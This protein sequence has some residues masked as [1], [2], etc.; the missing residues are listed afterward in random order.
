M[1][2]CPGEIGEKDYGLHEESLQFLSSMPVAVVITG[3]GDSI[4]RYANR[5]IQN[6]LGISP[7]QMVGTSAPNYYINPEVRAEMV[8]LLQRDGR[9]AAHEVVLRGLEGEQ[10]VC[11]ISATKIQFEAEDCFLFSLLNITS[12]KKSEAEVE[13]LSQALQHSP[14]AVFMCDTERRS[15]YAN[16]AFNKMTGYTWDEIAK[17][18]FEDFIARDQEKRSYDH[19]WWSLDEGKSWRGELQLARRGERFFWGMV[20]VTPILIGGDNASHFVFFLEDITRRKVA[21]EVLQERLHFI[22]TL[23]DAVP[24]PIYYKNLEGVYQGCNQAFERYFGVVRPLII[25]KSLEDVHPWADAGAVRRH[26]HQLVQNGGAQV[27]ETPILRKDG[28]EREAI[29]HKAVYRSSEGTP[30]GIVGCITDI[31]ERKKAER[32]ARENEATLSHVLEGI[33]AGIMVVD[34]QKH[35]VEDMNARAR[36]MLGDHFSGD[37]TGCSVWDC[38]L[39]TWRDES[40]RSVS[41]EKLLCPQQDKEY[42][43]S[44]ENG[45]G[46]PVSL[47]VLPTVIRGKERLLQILFDL[48]E[49]KVLE[50]QLNLAQKLES[51]GQLAAGIAHE[52]NTPVQYVGSNL[53]YIKEALG[54]LRDELEKEGLTLPQD[55]EEELREELPDAIQDAEEGVGRVSAIVQAMRKFSHPGSEDAVLVDVNEAIRNTVTIAR[56]EWKY[57]SEIQLE[58]ADALPELPCIPGD[59]NQVLLNILVNAAHAVADKMGD[60]GRKGQIRISTVLDGEYIQI[61]IADNGCGIPEEHRDVIF[62]PFF[63][64]KTVGRGTGQGLAITHAIVERQRGRIDFSSTPGEGTTFVIRF[65]WREAS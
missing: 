31:T 3:A 37:D 22:Q 55:V 26:D 29:I 11:L 6:L 19:M 44:Q 51:V 46:L 1:A 40:G 57:H 41:V 64:T 65:P 47:T 8:A 54:R 23:M 25:G 48:S 7:E 53:T 13:K 16:Q 27:Y 32:E 58:L 42:R 9:V 15:I 34:P 18:R 45:A 50:R 20:H 14:I 63:T 12:R 62:D 61:T 43:I 17:L 24:M 38:G 30:L 60:S 52:I 33:R 2:D 56:N 39:L 59:F 28:L 36:E 10:V 35:S 4:I 49:R 21:E 5:E